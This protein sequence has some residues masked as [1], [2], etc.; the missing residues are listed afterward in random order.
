MIG[1][2]LGLSVSRSIHDYGTTLDFPS[3]LH[4]R[5]PKFNNSAMTTTKF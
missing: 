4:L 1:L 5:H 2:S 3:Q